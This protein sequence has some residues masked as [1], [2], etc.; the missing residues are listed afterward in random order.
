MDTNK[1]RKYSRRKAFRFSCHE[2]AIRYRTAYD[3]R[4]AQLINISTTG[5]LLRDGKGHELAVGEKILLI[6]PLWD[7][8]PPV[9]SNGTVVRVRDNDAAIHF[10]I[11]EQDAVKNL[12]LFIFQNQGTGGTSLTQTAK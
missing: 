3:E 9:E 8:T 6:F 5:C 1:T 4:D 12:R 2:F 7:G 10:K 11:I